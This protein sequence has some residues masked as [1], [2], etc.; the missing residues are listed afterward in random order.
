[1]LKEDN[2]RLTLIL[3]CTDEIKRLVKNFKTYIAENVQEFENM[4]KHFVKN[5]KSFSSN[6]ITYSQT[7]SLFIL[8]NEFGFFHQ[9]I[10][11][12]YNQKYNEFANV[13]HHNINEFLER[14]S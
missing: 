8:L 2:D 11:L 6:L 4:G 5:S 13:F 9:N 1:M 3:A 12:T 14:C 7:E 10:G